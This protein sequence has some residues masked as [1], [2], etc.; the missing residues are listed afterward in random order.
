MSLISAYIVPGIP[1]PADRSSPIWICFD[2]WEAAGRPPANTYDDDSV[3][4]D[5]LSEGT[6]QDLLHATHCERCGQVFPF[7]QEA[8]IEK[9]TEQLKEEQGI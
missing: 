1:S 4:V 7:V 6:P 8:Y 3:L 2:C 5:A 9:A